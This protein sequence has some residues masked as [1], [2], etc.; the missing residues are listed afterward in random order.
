MWWM[1]CGH[2]EFG[3]NGQSSTIRVVGFLAH[4]SR[5]PTISNDLKEIV[6]KILG[7]QGFS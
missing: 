6:S 7:R 5:C 3:Q 4:D 2:S 1:C